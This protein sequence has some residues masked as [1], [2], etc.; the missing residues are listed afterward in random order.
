MGEWMLRDVTPRQAARALHVIEEYWGEPPPP[1]D[2]EP[3]VMLDDGIT[4]VDDDLDDDGAT[5]RGVRERVNDQRAAAG[6]E[7]LT[8]CRS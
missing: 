2:E 8:H 5:V 3:F 7:P 6:L 1:P 4:C